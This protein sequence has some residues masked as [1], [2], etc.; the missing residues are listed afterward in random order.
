MDETSVG[1]AQTVAASFSFYLL[2]HIQGGHVEFENGLH[3]LAFGMV[4]LPDL[5]ELAHGPHREPATFHLRV[6]FAN[7]VGNGLFF[8]FQPLHP[9]DELRQLLRRDTCSGDI[10]RHLKHSLFGLGVAQDPAKTAGKSSWRGSFRCE[11][12]N[13]AAAASGQDARRN[14]PRNPAPDSGPARRLA[15]QTCRPVRL[16]KN[17]LQWSSGRARTGRKSRASRSAKATACA[18]VATRSWRVSMRRPAS[19]RRVTSSSSVSPISAPS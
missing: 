7:I 6:D 2:I 3:L 12:R 16:G 17:A 4:L 8:L 9:F 10:C 1:S 18:L 19:P 13:A 5:D 15:A 14:Y 11:P